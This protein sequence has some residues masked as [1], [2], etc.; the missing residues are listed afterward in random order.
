MRTVLKKKLKLKKGNGGEGHFD[1]IMVIIITVIL[2]ITIAITITIT[3][4]S[5]LVRLGRPTGP[6]SLPEH[7][8]SWVKRRNEQMAIIESLNKERR[9]NWGISI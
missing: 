5:I 6:R 3:I 8:N 2:V 1:I 7:D 9:N 4:V